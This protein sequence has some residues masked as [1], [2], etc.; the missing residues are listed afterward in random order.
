VDGEVAHLLDPTLLHLK[1]IGEVGGHRELERT[2]RRLEAVVAQRDVLTHTAPDVT[3]AEDHHRRVGEPGPRLVSQHE[4][5]AERVERGGGERLGP[6]SVHA[7]SQLRQEP[8]VAEEHTVREARRHV[9][10]GERD[11]E[12]GTLDQRNDTTVATQ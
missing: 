6:L 2:E 9:A 8:R 4:R 11:R 10:R 12:G 7:E 3:V 5:G 1:K